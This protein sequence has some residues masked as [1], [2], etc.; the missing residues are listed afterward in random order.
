MSATTH[1]AQ[2]HPAKGCATCATMPAAYRTESGHLALDRR[3][4]A[5]VLAPHDAQTVHLQNV[6][7]MPAK[8]ADQLV[9]GD[10]TVWNFG[11]VYEV[12]AIRR[13]ASGSGVLVTLR[14]ERSGTTYAPRRHTAER[15]IAV[16]PAEARR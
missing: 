14:D 16:M 5:T 13:T 9:P 4:G 11:Y 6:G 8:R 10:R 3:T 7:R 12:V 2:T 1:Q 15:L